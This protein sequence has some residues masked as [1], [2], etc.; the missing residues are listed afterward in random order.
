MAL[1]KTV[2]TGYLVNAGYWSIMRIDYIDWQTREAQIY[3]SLFA[4]KS[5]AD[6]RAKPLE[7]KAVKFRLR[8]D[9][10]DKYL[11]KS[12]LAA[13]KKDLLAQLYTA[14][15]DELASPGISNA[16][17]IGDFVPQ[18]KDAADV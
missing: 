9:K 17:I 10:F 15:K 3:F 5:A 2:T 12:V 1:Q 16:D 6:A 14:F 4:D 7:A 11:S 18:L 8:A 13:S